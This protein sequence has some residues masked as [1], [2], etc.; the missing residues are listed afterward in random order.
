MNA[1]THSA[2]EAKAKVAFGAILNAAPELV[3]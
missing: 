2:N 3:V 1:A